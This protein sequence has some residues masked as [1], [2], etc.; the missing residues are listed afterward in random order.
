M[1]ASLVSTPDVVD[2]RAEGPR[3]MDGFDEEPEAAATV[4][5]ALP[6][7]PSRPR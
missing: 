6:R 4:A 3:P 1:S 7:P 2:L 5:Q